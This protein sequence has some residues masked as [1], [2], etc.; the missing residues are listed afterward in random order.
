MDKLC[1]ICNNPVTKFIKSRNQYWDWCS[2]K[3]MGRDPAILEKKQK[4][5][6]NK[7]GGHPMH[8]DA[9][10]QQLV[11]TFQSKYG[12]DNPSKSPLVK[13]KMRSTFISRY[14]V[15]NPSKDP[16]VIEKIQKSAIERFEIEK[17]SILEKRKKTNLE[18]YGRETNK[19]IHISQESLHLM[20]DIE[21]LRYQHF[22]LKKSCGQIAKELGISATPILTFF[23]E[24]NV[25][26]IRH[27]ISSIET[28]VIEYLHSITVCSIEQ[29]NRTI[30]KNKEIDIL[31]PD[32]NLAIE[33]NGIYWHS[34]EK[35]K[36]KKYHLDKTIECENANIHLLQIYDSEWVDPIK[37]AII[38]SK[39]RHLLGQSIK[40][41]ARKCQVREI[42]NKLYQSF[43][44]E[45]H[46]QGFISS[47][48]KIGLF[49]QDRL[50]SVAGFGK[51]RFNK[52]F[53]Y[54]LLR[55]C[56]EK[57]HT[58]VGGLSKILAYFDRLVENADVISYADRRW[59]NSIKGNLYQN[60]GFKLIGYSD[61]NYKY[62]HLNNPGLLLSRNQFQKHLLS[63]K[64]SI[65][66]S[67]LSEYQNMS[68]NRYYRIWDCGN[69]I[70]SRE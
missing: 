14:G 25:S 48:I 10:R 50:V 37:N 60:S 13:E 64:L 55:Y 45:N 52:Q 35:G 51:S 11:D 33:I 31:I 53:Q 20:K 2:N 32:K 16:A 15:D 19:Q 66:D 4:T 65:F 54:E 6:I 28:E 47:S 46:L 67:D 17:D 26:T 21:W 56:S 61:P 18:K 49:Y 5:N 27:S 12:V 38:K 29:S 44:S 59:T 30:L 24:N 39:L 1:K 43:V 23:A 70:Y 58:V 63:K 41:P 57:Y 68:L 36:S 34:E 9:V 7:F 3:C 62:F 69:L 8:N 40:I 22:E 42:D